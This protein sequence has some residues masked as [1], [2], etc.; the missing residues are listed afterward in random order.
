[1]R[2]SL[3]LGLWKLGGRVE[4]DPRGNLVVVALGAPV[5]R[6]T[7]SRLRQHREALIK[8]ARGELEPQPSV[9]EL[10]NTYR[11][12]FG[13]G[14]RE[15][16]RQVT[17]CDHFERTPEWIQLYLFREWLLDAVS[18]K[19]PGAHAGAALGPDRQEV[20]AT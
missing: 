2:E 15:A 5:P 12:A 1:M 17:G 6:D 10:T 9:R 18:K 4:V 11:R 19:G 20:K 3:L 7:L 16:F 13:D 8:A 14:F